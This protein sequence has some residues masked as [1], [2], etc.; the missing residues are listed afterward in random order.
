MSSR[1]LDEHRWGRLLGTM[2]TNTG[3]G[4]RKGQVRNRYQQY[5]ENTDRYDKYDGDANYVASKSSPG[6]YKGVETREP[7]K[8]PR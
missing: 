3:D 6:P 1:L 7:K 4:Y 8:P 2:A 5:N